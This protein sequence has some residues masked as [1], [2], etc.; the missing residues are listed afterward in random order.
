MENNKTLA[1]LIAEVMNHPDC[2]EELYNAMSDAL[3]SMQNRTGPGDS[4]A[5]VQLAL[6]R[7][8]EFDAIEALRESEK[9]H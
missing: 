5:W 7:Q 4:P 6:D 9:G 8:K 2:P 3:A 1:E